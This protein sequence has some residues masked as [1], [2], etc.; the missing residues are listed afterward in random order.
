MATTGRARS[1][2]VRGVD[3][4][5]GPRRHRKSRQR[6]TTEAITLR[7]RTV[8]K[9]PEPDQRRPTFTLRRLNFGTSWRAGD[10]LGGAVPSNCL[11]DPYLCHYNRSRKRVIL[12]IVPLFNLETKRFQK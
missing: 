5:I 1:I 11:P 12:S 3:C 9:Q 6:A 8:P 7:R 4:E 2:A 10:A